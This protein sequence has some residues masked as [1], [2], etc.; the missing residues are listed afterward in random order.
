M[1]R[2]ITRRVLP[3]IFFLLAIFL[4]QGFGAATPAGA[5]AI[6]SVDKVTNAKV[7]STVEVAVNIA[8]PSG[9]SG[10]QF[11]L[12]YDPQIAVVTNITAGSGLP[13]G[14]FLENLKNADRGNIKIVWLKNSNFP[15]PGIGG[16]LCRLV[17]RV[18]S[19]GSTDL[20]IKNLEMVDCSGNNIACTSRDGRVASG[21]SSSSS[22]GISDESSPGSLS[23][24]T[25]SLLPYAFRGTYYNCFLTASGG[26][27]GYTWEKIG[28]SFP[29]GLSMSGREI[30]GT[31]KSDGKYDFKLRV[32]DADGY[33]E[34][35]FTLWVIDKG[36][37]APHF[38][39]DSRTSSGSSERVTFKYLKV[40]Q[41]GMELSLSPENMPHVMVVD[42]SVNWVNL[43]VGLNAAGDTLFINNVRQSPSGMKAI[44][45]IKGTNEIVLYVISSGETSIKYFLTIYKIPA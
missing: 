26:T 30:F 34:K 38:Y 37:Q 6:I 22:G 35:S 14:T 27:G 9:M 44:P 16:E 32:S 43:Q 23:I 17:M 18:L 29:P 3:V 45:L 36:S 33:V 39:A 4:W 31:P 25:T 8:N 2:T 7:G 28:G 13:D 40:T 20:K 5:Q 11:D 15:D 19:T 12:V 10:F 21:G 41:G 24:G 42:S 1:T